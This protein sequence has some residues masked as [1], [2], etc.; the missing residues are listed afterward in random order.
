MSVP[1]PDPFSYE[2]ASLFRCDY[3]A[4]QLLS[5]FSD[6][7]LPL[8]DRKKVA[9]DK[10]LA[11]E[12]SCSLVNAK[13]TFGDWR[14]K[15]TPSAVNVFLRAQRKIAKL[16][17]PFSW[18]EAESHFGFGPGACVGLP[19]LKGDAY[20]KL[21]VK[22]SVT[23][24]N[25]MPAYCAVMRIPLWAESV[26]STQSSKLDLTHEQMALGSFDVVAGNKVVT[27]PKNAKTDRTIA[28]EPLMNVF[29]QMGIGRCIRHRL[30]RAGID[31]RTQET[32]QVLALQGSKDGTLA[33]IDLSGASDSISLRLVERLLPEDWVTALKQ[34]RSPR[35]VLPSG[36]LITYQKVSSMGNGYT[37]DLETLIFWAFSVACMEV[38]NTTREPV[39]IY[40]DDIV[41]N[42]VSSHLLIQVLSEFGFSTNLEKTF[43]S[44]VFRE[45]CGKH[46]FNGLDVTPF[47]IRHE[48]KSD[49]A[50]FT[51]A[52]NLRRWAW[53]PRSSTC[54]SAFQ[55]VHSLIISSASNKARSLR[56][57]DGYG[58]IGFV[59]NLDE[60]CPKWDKKLWCYTFKGL[61]SLSK[62]KIPND[63][64]F[65]LKCLY[66][67][68]R[69]AGTVSTFPRIV[70]KKVAYRLGTVRTYQW[71]DFGPWM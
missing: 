67:M 44:G 42:V 39:A 29:I 59:S 11:S 68:N 34:C 23:M 62:G 12:I 2:N 71:R 30:L 14:R 64:S 70:P 66:D 20:H 47:Y 63:A 19:R 69:S 36:E 56:I 54:D 3:L 55:S 9:L 7:D 26:F 37:F 61:I 46:Y 60:S 10:F 31:L 43:V 45:S 4:S 13:L 32:N 25:L 65:L 41:I 5:K 40:G 28:I 53:K 51:L 48:I 18:D 49:L 33:T 8:V 17:G 57:P 24:S 35:G 1:A 50:K 22:P 58:D 21:R 52:N 15:F 27:V 6:F 38:T 16:L